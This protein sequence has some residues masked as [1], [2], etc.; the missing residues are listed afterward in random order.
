MENRA[1]R[2]PA[3]RRPVLISALTGEGM[4][5][6]LADVE[7]RVA[8]GRVLVPLRLDAADGAGLSWLHRH[9]EVVEQQVRDGVMEVTVRVAPDKLDQLSRRFPQQSGPHRPAMS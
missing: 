1:T 7:R 3:E 6:L 8:A 5:A 2:L 9:V 4:E